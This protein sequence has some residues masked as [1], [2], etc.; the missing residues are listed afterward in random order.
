MNKKQGL[1]EESPHAAELAYLRQ[2]NETLKAKVEELRSLLVER[3]HDVALLQSST[4]M[5][6]YRKMLLKTGRKDPFDL[7]RPKIEEDPSDYLP[8]SK[9][10]YLNIDNISYFRDSV[11]IRGWAYDTKAMTV[12]KVVIRD[13]SRVLSLSSRWYPRTDVNAMMR[14]D[15]NTDTGYTI[16]VKLSDIRH[17]PLLVEYED[18]YGYVQ[19]VVDV[20][21]TEEERERYNE[22]FGEPTYATQNVAYNDWAHNHLV[23][24]EELTRQ[25]GETFPYMPLISICIPLYQTRSDYFD[26]LMEGLIHQSYSKIEICLADGSPDDS[27][28]EIVRPYLKDSRVIYR[29]LDENKGIAG[30]TN[31][32]FALAHGDFIMLC[33]H[34]DV[35]E[36]D[37]VYEIVKAIN[38]D[39]KTDLVYTD[40]NKLMEGENIFFSPN[41]KPDF[42]PDLLRSNNYITHILVVRTSIVRELG[43]EREEFDGAQDYD[44]ILRATE[45]ARVITHVPKFLYHWRAH[46][47]STAG[48]PESKMYAY[49]AGRRAI[50]AHYDRCGIPASV[51]QA[52]DIGSYRSVYR[53]QGEPL[54]SII[55]PNR[56]MRDVLKR[57]VDSIF[58]KSTY[59]NF[60]ILIV[61]NNSKTQEIFDY[62]RELEAAHANVRVLTWKEGFNY[63]AINNFAAGQAKGDYLL[64]LNN[65]VEV[66]TDRW[67]EE[68]LGYCQRP[69]VGI[70]G[71]RLYY[72]NNKLQ[73]AG[74]VVGL[75]GIA[76]H[77]CHMTKRSEGGYYGRVFKSQDCSAVT[78]AC[79]MV[80][81]KIY[82]EVGG[83]EEQFEVA[84]NDVDFCLKVRKLGLLVVYDAW[85]QLYHY[86]SLS[87][88]S[89]EAEVDREKHDRQMREAQLLKDR[90]PEIFEQGDPYF[91]PNLEYQAADYVLRGTVP[92]NYRQRMAKQEKEERERMEKLLKENPEY[93][94][95]VAEMKQQEEAEENEKVW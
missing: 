93:A 22:E 57:A 95:K 77:I 9:K 3:E 72:P 75:G 67:I 90:W 45:K 18:E 10:M 53:I 16:G 71:A 17:S 74:I 89:D 27:V 24:E 1:S 43:G 62:Y 82:E 87:R 80:S 52:P 59:R 13:R 34:D 51:E 42:N 6:I 25:A 85:C 36:K 94:A 79:L 76:G 81:K 47:E 56:D 91:N 23:T 33:D 11:Y 26:A 65:D 69:D 21:L 5:R 37:A 64:L 44:F 88:G 38:R 61:E 68:L 40:E 41:F 46:A 30:N 32:A 78:A 55:I 35:V 84:Y 20:M 31:A 73:H 29:H 66:I 2:E 60:E 49:E 7:L 70:C 48:K 63:S 8:G 28:E 58:E 4:A 92:K 19:R 39:E 50:E 12:P 83:L 15:E 14:I 86:E 54:V